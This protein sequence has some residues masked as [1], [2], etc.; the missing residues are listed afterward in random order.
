LETAADHAKV[1]SVNNR[2]MA[3][4]QNMACLAGAKGDSWRGG[5]LRIEDGAFAMD[6]LDWLSLRVMD[7]GN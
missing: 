2:I 6:R 1:A 5:L 7:V 3:E 4:G